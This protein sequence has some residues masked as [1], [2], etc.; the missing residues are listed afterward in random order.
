MAGVPSLGRVVVGLVRIVVGLDLGLGDARVGEALGDLVV[1]F[2][3]EQIPGSC[4]SSWSRVMFCCLEG[5]IELGLVSAED[6]VLT[7]ESI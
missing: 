6:C 2:L 7:I 5:G 4:S 1:G 3:E